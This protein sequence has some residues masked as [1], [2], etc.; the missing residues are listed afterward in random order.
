VAV[1]IPFP[2]PPP[3][4]EGYAQCPSCLKDDV[5]KADL[6]CRH[7]GYT[8]RI[9]M[10][11]WIGGA[12]MALSMLPLFLWMFGITQINLLP[13]VGFLLP[14]IPFDTFAILGILMFLAGLGLGFT[15]A[16]RIRAESRQYS[17]A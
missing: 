5:Y 15:A 8:L 1:K 9:P 12:L 3:K 7:C 10:Y 4:L 17:T 13:L 2:P 16:G 6:V 14:E 11:G